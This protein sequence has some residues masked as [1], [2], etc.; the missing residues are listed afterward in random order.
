MM[1]VQRK[2]TT[3]S[4]S[5]SVRPQTV[6]MN[7]NQVKQQPLRPKSAAAP[8]Q[9][10]AQAKPGYDPVKVSSRPKSAAIVQ[11]RIIQDQPPAYDRAKVSSRLTQDRNYQP[12]RRK[13]QSVQKELTSQDT[14]K[15]TNSAEDDYGG[16]DF[17]EDE[18]EEDDEDTDRALAKQ[19]EAWL[20]DQAIRGRARQK[21]A[22][23]LKSSIQEKESSKD[24]AYGFSGG[25]NSR[26]H[27]REPTPDANNYH[28]QPRIINHHYRGLNSRGPPPPVSQN[29]SNKRKQFLSSLG[30]MTYNTHF[31]LP[32]LSKKCLVWIKN[33]FT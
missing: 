23:A 30:R 29:A 1:T 5:T 12:P 22:E 27:T 21:A 19:K 18:E 2:T 10:R 8:V 17:E 31:L 20:F 13:Q 26:L 3:S 25:E 16:D 33:V 14:L 32:K 28:V 6:I 24:S 4:A 15:T 11:K 7:K 9:K